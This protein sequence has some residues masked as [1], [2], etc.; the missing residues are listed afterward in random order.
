MR[1]A[2]FSPIRLTGAIRKHYRVR[3]DAAPKSTRNRNG[4]ASGTDATAQQG[5][6]LSRCQI[7]IPADILSLVS[8]RTLKSTLMKIVLTSATVVAAYAGLLAVPQPLFPFSVR[9]ENLVLYSDRPFSE[10]AAKHMLELAERKL[11]R[12]PL[13]SGRQRHNIFI[14]N[15]RWRQMLFFNKDYGV[16]GVAQYPITANVFLRDARIEENRLISPRGNLVIGDRTLDYFVAHE[17]THQ[18]TGRAIG[19]LRFYALPRWVREG[20]A[21]YVGKGDSFDY[22]VAMRAFLAGTPEMDWKKSG[23]YWRFHLLVAYV[24]DHQHLNVEQ[25][26]R[27]PPSAAAVETAVTGEKP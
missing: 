22:D 24:L 3:C 18:I 10:A 11:V 4:F 20:Y 23:L 2:G 27:A 17:I 8:V 15:S 6:Q 16:A 25:L 13:Y 1:S 26:L 19:P 9:A 12:S 5:C 21:D 14:C 7:G